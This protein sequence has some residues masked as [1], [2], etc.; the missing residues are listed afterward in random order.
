MRP[1]V[2]RRNDTRHNGIGEG[3]LTLVRYLLCLVILFGLAGN[4][5][6][7]A[8]PCLLMTQD[9]VASSSAMPDCKM[10]AGCMDCAAKPAKSNGDSKAPKGSGCM[11]MASCS[12]VLG[13]KAPHAPATAPPVSV[14]LAFWPAAPILTGP[15]GGRKR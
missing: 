6:A 15:Q 14:A 10:P 13:V 11:A 4:G 7:V 3:Q 12:A 8:A 5:A 2:I 9:Q 1:P